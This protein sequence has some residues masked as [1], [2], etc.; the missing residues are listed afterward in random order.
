LTIHL[1]NIGA[2]KLILWLRNGYKIQQKAINL[3]VLR[4]GARENRKLIAQIVRPLA[5]SASGGL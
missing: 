3:K 2:R 4:V 5:L 1:R